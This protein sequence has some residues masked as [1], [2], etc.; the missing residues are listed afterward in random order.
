MVTTWCAADK[1]KGKADPVGVG[2]SDCIHDHHA[3]GCSGGAGA[4]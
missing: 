4:R 2:R 1:G 3:G